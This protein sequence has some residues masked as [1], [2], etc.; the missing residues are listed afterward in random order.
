MYIVHTYEVIVQEVKI[1]YKTD[2]RPRAYRFTIW[3]VKIS[4]TNKRMGPQSI[5]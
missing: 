5:E 4:N 1:N 2:E 3:L